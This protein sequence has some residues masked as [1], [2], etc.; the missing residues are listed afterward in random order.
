MNSNPFYHQGRFLTFRASRCD[1][2][3][4]V[5]VEVTGTPSRIDIMN[6]VAAMIGYHATNVHPLLNGFQGYDCCNFKF[7]HPKPEP[8]DVTVVLVPGTSNES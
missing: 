7:V 8:G 1:F 3:E 4:G 2:S 5:E 6:D